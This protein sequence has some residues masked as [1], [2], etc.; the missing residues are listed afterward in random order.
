MFSGIIE[1][2]G[3]I[4]CISSEKGGLSLVLSVE[5]ICKLDIGTSVAVNGTCL[6]LE[7]IK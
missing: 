6:T 1:K 2:L 5:P 7:N 3:T 4:T